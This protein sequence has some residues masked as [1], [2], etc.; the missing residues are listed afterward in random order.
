[1]MALAGLGVAV[2]NPV[3][4]SAAAANPI[5][6]FM[7]ESSM[8][9]PEDMQPQPVASNGAKGR[10]VCALCCLCCEGRVGGGLQLLDGRDAGTY[11]V[12]EVFGAR[13]I[14][15]LK[16]V[17]GLYTVDPKT[18]PDATFI[19]EIRADALIRMQ[20][21]TLPIEPVI[22]ELLTRAKLAR[23]IRIVNGLIPGSLSRALA[24]ERIGTVIH[25]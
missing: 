22:L 24:G 9:D 8:R 2:T 23:S 1:M 4:S 16:D 18:H 25:A 11:L 5:G 13:S 17:D 12:G 6:S 21:P 20:L 10:G 14:I 15:L 3:A 7:L 19:P